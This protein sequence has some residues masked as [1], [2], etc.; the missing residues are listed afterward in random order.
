[1]TQPLLETPLCDWHQKHGGRMVDFAGWK[2]PVQYG[3]IVEEHLATRNA[4]GLFDVS[5]MGRLTV[6]G[7]SSLN[8]LESLLTRRVAGI[9]VGQAR[10]TLI[11]SESPPDSAGQQALVAILDDALVSRDRNAED[12]S[13]RMGL[14]VNGSNRA[15]VVAWLESQLPVPGNQSDE[16]LS[17]RDRTL[18]TAMIAV[19]GPL[20]IDIVCG[21]CSA[22]DAEQIRSLMNY[23]ASHATVAGEPAS[24][25]RTGY[26]GE[27]G[28]EIVVA[29]GVA[30]DV[31]MAIHAAGVPR[32]LLACGLGARDT[33][34]LE[35]GMPLYG[36]ELR[37]DTDPFAI[38]LGLAVNLDGRVFPGVNHLRALQADRPCRVRVGL[39]LDS[40]RSAREGAVVSQGERA[41]G[42]VTSGSFAPTL[43][44]AVAMAMVDRDLAVPGTALEVLVRDTRQAVRVTT[45]PFYRRK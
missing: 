44:A 34:R 25:S 29:A 23:R 7:P 33:L 37:E 12:G 11:A 41:V 6:D 18:A 27:D 9:E 24:V 3:S 30:T 21:L 14:V 13:P 32:G 39:T 20:A 17:F 38:G 28:L 22:A 2:M 5:H 1:M 15:R 36:H 42:V 45:L 43:N 16:R 31:W 8:W 4:A 35:A 40:K 19:Q 26:T 10:Y